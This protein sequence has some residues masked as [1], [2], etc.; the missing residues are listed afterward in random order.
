M[1]QAQTWDLK[2]GIDW[3][4][5]L[6]HRSPSQYGYH[7]FTRADCNRVASINILLTQTVVCIALN[8]PHSIGPVDWSATIDNYPLR[9]AV[10]NQRFVNKPLCSSQVTVCAV[11]VPDCIA[12]AVYGTVYVHPFAFNLDGGS[13]SRFHLRVTCRFV[14]KW[15][16][17]LGLKCRYPATDR[18][19]DHIETTFCHYFLS[20]FAGRG[21]KP[22]IILCIKGS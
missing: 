5:R 20:D 1:I 7:L 9:S 10:T 22:S 3:I 14:G 6:T 17:T 13:S 8:D 16:S 21:C 11:A 19:M 18:R 15:S 4:R 2:P 12:V